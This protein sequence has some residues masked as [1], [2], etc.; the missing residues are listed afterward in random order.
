MPAGVPWP[1]YLRFL[2][3]GLLS[4]LAG[5]QMVHYIYKP[6]LQP[7]M[8]EEDIAEETMRNGDKQNNIDIST[9]QVS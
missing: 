9:N 3:A 8:A 5:A 7:V 1:P 4:M 6:N 2:A